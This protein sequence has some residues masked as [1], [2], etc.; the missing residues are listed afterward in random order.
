VEVTLVEAQPDL[1]RQFRGEGLMPSGLEVLERIGWSALPATIPQRALQ[2]WTFVVE[3]TDLFRAE[4]PM[5]SPHACTLID[6]G[7]LLASLLEEAEQQGAQLLKGQA[8]AE[9]L[10]EQGRICGVRLA[11]GQERRADLVIG[12][13]GRDSSLRRLAQ[14]AFPHTERPID[15]LWF[16]LSGPESLPL[17]RWLAGRFVT[18]VGA[19]GSFALFETVSGA[20]QLGWALQAP[21]PEPAQAWPARWAGACSA[22][23]ADLL[24]AIAPEQIEGP[25]RLPV[26]V[27]LLERWHRPGL[28]LLGDAAHP[29]SPVRAQGINMALRDAFVAAGEL[30]RG[31]PSLATPWDPAQIEALLERITQLRLPEIRTIQGLQARELQRAQ[32]LHRNP[33]LRRLL[34]AGARLWGPLLARRW[35]HEQRQLREGL[36]LPEGPP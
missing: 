26:R 22:P 29:M 15:V 36:P 9:L 23:L 1:R 12:C 35:I 6:Q 19:A 25:V 30:S 34:S 18:V 24:A 7:S 8:V 17:V 20:V 13:D 3:G 4:E 27:G 31:L 33:W 10:E 28:L 11:D 21:L 5:G 14:L 32:L 16:R 2:G